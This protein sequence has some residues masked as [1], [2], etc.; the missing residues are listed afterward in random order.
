MRKKI[1]LIN[2][3]QFGYHT[4]SYNYCKYLKDAF[5]ITYISFD[6][7]KKKMEE[8]GVTICYVPYHG[9][10][11]TRGL[12][13]IKYCR[14]YIK[15]NQVD[16]IFVLY[17]QL[18]SLLKIGLS[19][20]KFLLD[21][22]TGAVGSTPKKRAI[23]DTIMSFE[24][25]FFKHITV[26]SESLRDK[27]G[28]NSK[29]CH[30]LPLG[31]DELSSTD[32]LFHSIHLLYVGTLSFRD[33]DKTV[34]GLSRFIQKYKH[35]NLD[36]SYDIFGSG[37]VEAEELLRVSISETN[38]ENI[39]TFHGRKNH[40][41][42]QY[43]FDNCN[44]GVAYVPITDYYDVQPPTKIFEYAR[45]GM[46]NIATSTYENRRLITEDNGVICDDTIDSFSDALET[47]YIYKDKWNSQQIRESLEDF[48]WE[49]I[50][51]NNLKKYLYK[52]LEKR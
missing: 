11:L 43:Y 2:K 9:S 52:I 4:N 12:N 47:I 44:V 7:D 16:L 45:A 20:N 3:T 51:N 13:F 36:I 29:K 18:S 31:A 35:E 48:S 50:V 5:D 42:I 33:I 39:V 24:T 23:A 49:K 10:V 38:L 21:I 8:S 15:N 19:S 30:I 22:R 1:L 34:F 17:F 25:H 37:T 26:I 46:V 40:K 41:E 32:K 27:L 6:T 14:N 28:L